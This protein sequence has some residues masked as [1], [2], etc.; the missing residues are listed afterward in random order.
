MKNGKEIQRTLEENKGTDF[1]FIMSKKD[2]ET[3]SQVT[4]L[5]YKYLSIS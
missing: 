2:I 5:I 3:C 1:V 4:K